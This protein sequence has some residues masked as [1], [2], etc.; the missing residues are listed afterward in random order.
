MSDATTHET[1]APSH[2]DELWLV[3]YVGT[4]YI[5][6]VSGPHAEGV[7]AT[8]ERVHLASLAP[9][10]RVYDDALCQLLGAGAAA[11]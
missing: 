9:V 2:D 10:W 1:N 6:G 11:P 4:P 5:F 8:D 7:H 3:R